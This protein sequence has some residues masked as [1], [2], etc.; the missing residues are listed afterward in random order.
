MRA[1]GYLALA[2][3]VAGV[4]LVVDAVAE[5]RA[6]VSLVVVIPVVSGSSAEFLLG[7]A[8]LAGGLFSL[9]WSLAGGLPATATPSREKADSGAGA[10]TGGII[11]VG[12]VPLLFG[13]WRNVPARTR[14]ILALVG[15]AL[16]VLLAIGWLLLVVR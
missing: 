2:A 10:A 9:P 8:L 3:I 4:A 6:L 15:A 12:P 14:W 1:A 13:T 7:V 5:G 11:L 16:L